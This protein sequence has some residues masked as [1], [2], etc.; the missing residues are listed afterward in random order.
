MPTKEH[1]PFLQPSHNP[2]ELAFNRRTNHRGGD[3]LAHDIPNHNV[4]AVIKRNKIA[5]IARDG[6]EAHDT[7]ADIH[8]VRCQDRFTPKEQTVLDDRADFG[9]PAPGHLQRIMGRFT[10]RLRQNPCFVSP[11]CDDD[12]ATSRKEWLKELHHLKVIALR[13]V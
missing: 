11:P 1:R 4:K 13:A 12:V 6:R 8:A 2:V 7:Y 5:V 9:F 3:A 10:L